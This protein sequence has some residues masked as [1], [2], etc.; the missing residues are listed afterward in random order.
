VDIIV[1]SPT[2]AAVAARQATTEIPIV[3]SAGD[4]VG[5][6]LISSLSRP[7]AN[8][9]G[10]SNTSAE[11]GA[12][13]LDLIRMVLPSARRIAALANAP[14]PFSRSFVDQIEA[15]GRKIG[16]DIKTIRVLGVEELD[17]AFA[18]MAAEQVDAV[19]VQPTLPR[20]PVIALATKHRLP[21]LGSNELFAR[22]G[23]LMSYGI[24]LRDS[25]RRVARYVDLILKGSKP[26]DLPVEQPVRYQLIINLKTARSLGIRV[27]DTILAIADEAIE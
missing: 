4:P 25:Y 6:G 5:T 22:E 14:D 23:G 2:P 15:A 11:A 18:A 24:V 9:T 27:P 12:K 19:I 3:I 10:V 21:I 13:T 1:A 8:V 17:A 16:I 26:S 20:K 7:G